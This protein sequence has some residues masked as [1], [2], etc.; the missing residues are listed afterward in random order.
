MVNQLLGR[1]LR[2]EDVLKT[3][4]GGP[5]HGRRYA[6]GADALE[7]GVE[8]TIHRYERIHVPVL[9]RR[10]GAMVLFVYAGTGPQ[11]AMRLS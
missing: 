7:R 9:R 2:G 10:R 11:L 1:H 5:L 4:V 6:G 8:G 3:L